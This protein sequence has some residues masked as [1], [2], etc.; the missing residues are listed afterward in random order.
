MNRIILLFL[1]LCAPGITYGQYKPTEQGSTVTF[2]IKN[3]GFDVNGSFKGFDGTIN[4]DP[5][6]SGVS[7][8]DVTINA[9]T[10]NID[11]SL[12]DEHLKGEAYFDIKNY[13]RIRLVSTKISGKGGTYLFTGQLTI[14]GKSKMVSFPFTATATA[15]GFIFKGLFK[16]NRKDFNLGGTSTIANELEVDLNINAKNENR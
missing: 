13:P 14:K 8:F 3:L 5:Q 2:V 15:D 10:I 1:V 11:N 6:N 9:V 12:R 4:F 7:N 16:I